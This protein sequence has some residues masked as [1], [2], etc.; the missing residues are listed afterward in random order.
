[1]DGWGKSVL[2]SL[3]LFSRQAARESFREALDAAQGLNRMLVQHGFIE[4]VPFD[5]IHYFPK[6]RER[7]LHVLA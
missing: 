3:V 2:S 1:M 6:G 4:V 5:L 7:V